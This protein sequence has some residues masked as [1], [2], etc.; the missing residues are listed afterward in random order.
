MRKHWGKNL[1]EILTKATLISGGLDLQTRLAHQQAKR[2]L[3]KAK[4]A[5]LALEGQNTLKAITR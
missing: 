3:W 2:R 4:D 5:G 1:A